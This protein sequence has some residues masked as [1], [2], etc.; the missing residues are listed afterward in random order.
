MYLDYTEAG[1][2]KPLQRSA[3]RSARMT[4]LCRSRPLNAALGATIIESAAVR[5][6]GV[7]VDALSNNTLQGSA[8]SAV[9]ILTRRVV[10]APPERGR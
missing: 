10:P 1:S 7:L 2:N 9:L 5:R 3:I 4:S 6:G 8:R